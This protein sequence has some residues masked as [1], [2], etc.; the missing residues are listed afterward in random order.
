MIDGEGLV[1]VR[2]AD[3]L[4]RCYEKVGLVARVEVDVGWSPLWDELLG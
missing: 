4:K 2:E 1:Q 3:H